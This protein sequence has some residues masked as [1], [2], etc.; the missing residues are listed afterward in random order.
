M[1]ETGLIGWFPGFLY[2]DKLVLG[3]VG[4]HYLDLVAVAFAEVREV[5]GLQWVVHALS[6][7][8]P[9]PVVATAMVYPVLDAG[10]VATDYGSGFEHHCMALMIW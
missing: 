7:D 1:Q 9:V 6:I 3:S 8:P 2:N 5:T 4:I 10:P